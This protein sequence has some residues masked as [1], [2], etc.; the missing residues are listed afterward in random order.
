MRKHAL[1]KFN[2][3]S[4]NFFLLQSDLFFCPGKNLNYKTFM[5]SNLHNWNEFEFG[6]LKIT[7][8]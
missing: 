1:E 5:E 8:F 7:Q 6:N 3:T 4:A 2:V